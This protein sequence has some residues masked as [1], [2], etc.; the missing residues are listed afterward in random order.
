MRLFSH[1]D[2]FLSPSPRMQKRPGGSFA[3]LP[4]T[5]AHSL[6][7]LSTSRIWLVNVARVSL[8][9]TLSSFSLN[10]T[11]SLNKD[12]SLPKVNLSNAIFISQSFGSATTLVLNIVQISF[13]VLSGSSVVDLKIAIAKEVTQI[14][15]LK[16]VCA[17][18]A[19]IIIAF[20]IRTRHWL[21]ID[22]YTA[23]PLGKCSLTELSVCKECLKSISHRLRSDF[24]ARR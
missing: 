3:L 1:Q 6:F 10:H 12:P 8:C 17:S 24:A 4:R 15:A 5:L 20:R 2:F 23:F 22:F 13:C 21:K 18:P 7:T 9:Q 16:C 19:A 11:S 14:A